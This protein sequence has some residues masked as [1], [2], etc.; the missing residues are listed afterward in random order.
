VP[1]TSRDDHGIAVGIDLGAKTGEIGRP[2]ERDKHFACFR[3][4]AAEKL[5]G[6]ANPFGWNL[7]TET[8]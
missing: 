3:R 5:S 1:E 4:A 2:A 6:L 7:R 8:P